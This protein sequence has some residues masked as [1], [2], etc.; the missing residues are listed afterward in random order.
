MF[1]LR[2]E[3][4]TTIDRLLLLYLINEAD[5]YILLGRLL[6]QKLTFLSEK[7]M[8]SRRIKGLNYKFFRWEHGPMTEQIYQDCEMLHKAGLIDRTEWPIGATKDGKLLLESFLKFTEK[9]GN[10]EILSII[11]NVVKKYAR[12]SASDIKKLVYDI[13]IVPVGWKK[14]VRIGN[15]PHGDDIIMKLEEKEVD[16]LF[17]LNEEDL[18]DLEMSLMVT[19]EM[20]ELSKH[21]AR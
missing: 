16:K 7:G 20:M 3:K 15:I 10:K 1:A 8:I 21:S 13:V 18:D 14:K 12:L 6:L 19:K 17:R 5:K 2:T 11:S 4:E 9:E